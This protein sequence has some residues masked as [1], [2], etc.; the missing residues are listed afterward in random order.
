[1]SR[2]C[3]LL[4][5][6]ALFGTNNFCSAQ[7]SKSSAPVSLRTDDKIFDKVTTSD[8]QTYVL[9]VKAGHA[10]IDHFNEF[11][12]LSKTNTFEVPKHN[13]EWPL[14]YRIFALDGRLALMCVTVQSRYLVALPIDPVSLA[15][16]GAYVSLCG[17]QDFVGNRDYQFAV[18]PNG[19]FLVVSSFAY[20]ISTS[21]NPSYYPGAYSLTVVNNYLGVVSRSKLY[22]YDEQV[23]RTMTGMIVTDEGKVISTIKEQSASVVRFEKKWGGIG[24]NQL[25]ATW[26]FPHNPYGGVGTGSRRLNEV[27]TSFALYAFAIGSTE[28]QVTRVILSQGRTM[29][30]LL[31]QEQGEGKYTLA[32]I[33]SEQPITGR[34]DTILIP[35]KYKDTTFS[36]N[37]VR[38]L[39][40][41]FVKENVIL[42]ADVSVDSAFSFPSAITYDE[43]EGHQSTGKYTEPGTFQ[44]HVATR[45][46]LK[47]ERGQWLVLFEIIGE[48]A[49]QS[50][51][52]MI[53]YLVVPI[54]D[55]AYI[56]KLNTVGMNCELTSIEKKQM[57]YQDVLQHMSFVY[58]PSQNGATVLCNEFTLATQ[59]HFK[60]HAL[61]STTTKTLKQITAEGKFG[62]TSDAA[63]NGY[64]ILSQTDERWAAPSRIQVVSNSKEYKLV[65]FE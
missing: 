29:V 30:D 57:T 60:A 27:E 20:I 64:C 3:L 2:L 62:S 51:F 58:I 32:G 42:G 49:D 61:L 14:A 5:I 24:W 25:S 53:N 6:A 43:M 33:Y 16:A 54:C 8:G 31:V 13:G 23:R 21:K 35:P 26:F 15:P 38:T 37:F 1:M 28:P 39:N 45:Q 41:A 46:I 7:V 17:E 12:L 50:P 59:N 19:K 56:A 22:E 18:S 9:R 63:L 40:G 48:R 44:R 55:N 47:D 36:W 10:A 11:L 4:L 52:E 65:L 34:K